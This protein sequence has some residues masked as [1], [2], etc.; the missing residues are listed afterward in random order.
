MRWNELKSRRSFWL[1]ILLLAM[2][3]IG[4]VAVSQVRGEDPW[5]GPN[6]NYIGTGPDIMDQ[7]T[8]DANEAAQVTAAAVADK[9][10]SDAQQAFTGKSPDNWVAPNIPDPL[11][12]TGIMTGSES[13]PS[14]P[15]W[16][17]IFKFEN[18]WQ[19]VISGTLYKAYAGTLLEDPYSYQLADPNLVPQG[20]IHIQIDPLDVMSTATTSSGSYTTP[21]RTG[22]LHITAATGLCLTLVSTNGT[23]YQ[24]DVQSGTWSCT[25][26]DHDPAP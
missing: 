24:F 1:L 19:E 8:A 26:A 9:V 10:T 15:G 14:M 4:L 13:L 2:L 11:P 20:I 21:T 16:G 6:S 23:T 3:G 25:P 12:P 5:A 7:Q 18:T 17:H 22:S